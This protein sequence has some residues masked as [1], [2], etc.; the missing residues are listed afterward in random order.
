MSGMP[1]LA[2]KVAVI[3]GGASGIG[4]GIAERLGAQ[5][6]Q[7]V[8]ADLE[9]APLAK[10]AIE[11]GA[12]GIRTDVTSYESVQAL[13]DEVKRRFGRVHLICNNAGVASTAQIA[14]MALS[15]WSWILDVNFWG[16]IHGIK[17][18]LPLLQANPDGGHL[19][20][21]ASVAGFHV[22]PGLGGYTVSKFA[23]MALSETLAA[24]LAATAS[25][26]GVTILCPG[27][28]STK[29]GSSQRNRPGSLEG[30]A[31]VDRDLEAADGGGGVRWMEPAAVGDVLVRAI[32]RGDLYALTHP[33]WFSI[34]QGRHKKITEAFIE[35]AREL[36]VGA[37]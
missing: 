29:L 20:N 14:D 17:A 5:G 4:R 13:A 2:G 8:I 23:V 3:T 21:T 7:I 25:R 12:L 19:V 34:V 31:L 28:V 11:I 1:L 26:V 27:P 32:Q 9:E 18:F 30:G 33:E 37:R 16:V 35:S 22:T 24:E 10:T 36:N 6:M 15:D